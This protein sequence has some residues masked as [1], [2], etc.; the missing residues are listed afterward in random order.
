[1]AVVE[2]MLS[3]GWILDTSPGW[4]FTALPH[5]IDLGVPDDVRRTIA[6]QFDRL[7]PADQSLLQAAS[8]AG[9][10]FAAQAIA[11]PLGWTLDEVEARCEIL[12]HSQRFLRDAG[13]SAWPDGTVARRYAFTHQLYRQ[14]VYEGTSAGS[15][16]RLHQRVGEAL[17]AAHGERATEIAAELAAHFERGRDPL[18]ALRYLRAAAERAQ[19]RFARR[20][21]AGYLEAAIAVAAQ[22]PDE[23]ERDRQELD[24]RNALA[25]ILTDVYGFASGELVQNCERAYELCGK[26][27]SP[28]Q[29]FQI[30]YVLCHVRAV[31][32]DKSLAP[33]MAEK[34]DTLAQRLGTVDHRLLA[35][36]I[37]ARTAVYQG[38]FTDACRLAEGVL[39]AQR[40]GEAAR[41]PPEY[42]TDPLVA[43]TTHCA[44]ALWF[45][46]HT[47]RAS[48][49]MHAGLTTARSSGSVF[50]EVAALCHTAVLAL[51]SRNPARGR[52]LAEQA[53]ALAAEHE[54]VYWEAMA[55]ALMGWASAQ[56]GQV[57][58]AIEEL[59]AA[60]AAH[61]AGGTLLFY[62]WILGFVAEAHLRAGDVDA[63]LAAADE[64]L[65]LAETT[66][67]RSYCPELWRLKGELLLAA[68]AAEEAEQCLRRAL[69]L[70]R[71]TESK[72][73]ELRTATSLARMLQAGGR[74]ADARAVLEEICEWFGAGASS[75]DSIDARALLRQLSPVESR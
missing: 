5:E 29:L 10:E 25:P 37:L 28:T 26:V 32:N 50:T 14:A 48:A 34:L 57:R 49:T 38:R 56:Q 21:A 35:D 51:L 71:E 3:R 68:S 70:S 43:T 33:A 7:G 6:M 47:D 67:D 44:L 69:E 41:R 73:L 42:G 45:L 23:G 72:S 15:R 58:E 63:G 64:G 17:E 24:L 39:S 13:R 53:F 19:Q 2:H 11:A 9:A 60:R 12:A 54:L 20:E 61:R 22:L 55:S 40:H 59:E 36:S 16:Q 1:M 66:F 8:V 4:A 62:T 27:G 52:D 74:S 31:R 30:V 18:R 65:R 75:P 46:G